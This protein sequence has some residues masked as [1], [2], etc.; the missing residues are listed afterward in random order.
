[1][2]LYQYYSGAMVFVDA[3]INLFGLV[4]MAT[5]IG[6]GAGKLAIGVVNRVFSK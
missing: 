6:Y 5:A 4:F 3:T 1:M 2:I